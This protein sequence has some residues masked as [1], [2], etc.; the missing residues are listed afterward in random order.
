VS[1]ILG[2]YFS[3]FL[4]KFHFVCVESLGFPLFFHDLL[5]KAF[6]TTLQFNIYGSFKFY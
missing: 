5:V 2:F 6:H 1:D 3:G 4:G